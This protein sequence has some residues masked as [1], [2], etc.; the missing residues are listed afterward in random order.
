MPI[1]DVMTRDRHFITRKQEQLAKRKKDG[2]PFDRM[3]SEL[4][5]M[6]EK[7]AALYQARLGSLPKI[8]YDES[9]PVA[10][11]SEE[12]VK[13]IQDNQVVIIA[14][15][16]GSGKTTQLPK[17]CL[18]AG[19]G[20]AG[21]IGHTQPRRIAARS[22]AER[23]SDEMQVKLGEQ[24]GFQVRFN[25][26][27]NEETLIK[28]MT[29]G[30]L[31]AEIQQ[32]K[33]LYK[34]DTII[35]DEAHERSLNIDFL[36]GYL[37]RVLALRPDLKVIVTSATIDVE[38]FSAHFN[39]APVIEVS[40]RT[41]PVEIRYQPL[42][43]KS[44]SEALDEDQSMEQGILDAVEQLIQEERQSGYRGAGD[45]LVFLAGER[46]I[47]ETAEILRR[48][49]LRNTE[50]LPLYARLSTSEQQRIFKSHSG[51]RIVLSTNV[52]ETSL[53]VPGIRYVIDPGLAR[54]SRY[55]VRSKVQQ[56]P[57]EKI[58]QASANQRAGRCGRVAE[59]VCIRLYDE[60]DFAARS[61]FTDPE[62]FRT[63][64]AS[65]ILQMANLR[66]GAV[67]KFP[68]VEM[69]ERRM[70]ND[71][72][73]ALT[74]LGALKG[75]QLTPIGRQLAKLPI[76]PKFG[77]ILIAA[78]Q[79]SVLKEVAV[80]VSA[81]SVPDPRERPQDKK[82]QSDQA[83]AQDKDE[84]SDFVVL[85]NLWERFEEQRQTLSQNQL[86]QYCRKQFLNFMR[87]R[88][89]RDIHRQI[90]IACKQLGFKEVDHENRNYEAIHRSLLAG[91]FTHVA[92]KMDDSK[93]MLGC[94]S[95]KVSIFPGS[96][97]F[98]K[99]PQW[100][101]AAELV[102]TSKLYARVT[103]RIDPEWIEEF[104]KPFVKRQYFDPHFERNQGR[105]MAQEQVSL[106]G[107]IIVAKRRVDYGQI[108]PE[109]AREILIRAGLVEGQ[110]RTKQAFYRHNKA[111]VEA[112][113][114]QEA[115]LRTR[116]ILVD[117]EAVFA[118]YDQR[119]PKEVRNQKGLEYFVKQSPD[120]LL[121]T[122][123]DLINQEVSVDDMAFPDTYG[124][125]G[126]ALP[127][128]YRFEPG[129]VTDGATLKVPVGL[130]RQLSLDELGWAVPGFIKER[131]EALLRALPKALRR[132][133]V[134]I[135]QFVER[136]Y[137]NLSKDKGDLLEQL[138]LQIKRETLI[139]I[140]LN[141]WAPE[142][143][144]THLTLT[145][146]VVDERGKVL[147]FG[148]DLAE[149]QAR[150]S[151]LVEESF[152][153]FGT[154]QH[155]QEDLTQWPEQ[156]IP[157]RQE[158]KQAGIK[159]TAFP[160]LV[161]QGEAVSLK[162]FDDHSTAQEAHRKGVIALL[163]IALQKDVRYLQ[164]NLPHLRESMLIFAPLG[165]KEVLLNDLLNAILDKVFLDG[166]AL[167]RTQLE[168]EQC[169]SAHKPQ[170][171]SVA[172]EMA[173]QLYRVLS[174]YQGVAKKMKGSIPL[175]WTRVYGD[176]KLQLENLIYPGFIGSTPL[177]WLGQLPRY[178]KG[179]E[180]RL[181]RFQ[182]HLNKENSYVT[183]LEG[184]WQS[185][186]KQKKA[187]DEKS[188]YDPELIKYRWMLEEYR[189]S[190]F[191]QSVGT[192]EPISDKRLGKQWQAVKKLV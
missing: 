117:D 45:I 100:V 169:I 87:M 165:Q 73:R 49:E 66:L 138:S 121:M 177:F 64:L 22:V 59:G 97:L 92:N 82:T 35:I 130:L 32:D 134:P 129:K 128:D 55:S 19:R 125:N 28:L 142:R 116:D 122:R 20:I 26:E 16:T 160:A 153:K 192:L 157:E 75:E 84:D 172:N 6:M 18:E 15:E 76:D 56:L 86:R 136:I 148:K 104:A 131:C 54:M 181:E 14:G 62:I 162:M 23:I 174:S 145:L 3:A 27:S 101:M 65:V 90:L 113:E 10:A 152:A 110:M 94:R 52:A 102:E 156:D 118:F 103:A 37:K 79:H 50:V 99:P 21:L 89:W 71:G 1:T 120:A 188:L 127:I 44:D 72:Y 163:K 25:D 30:I 85:L 48:A 8:T 46:E 170:L 69:P 182:N 190:L 115:K 176:I 135:P 187:H 41:Y 168:F 33:L 11:R 180:V 189:I 61:E 17:M 42:L 105:V 31:L 139:D 38:R 39:N 143:L 96:M 137:P 167:P 158:I 9:L 4:D 83:H 107:L 57:I 144:E 155:E 123:E 5:A 43:S 185:Y 175:P 80:I 179:I 132:R 159:V 81:L 178:F 119:I 7:S 29:D 36:L 63:N 70:I 186:L 53:T 111:L 112:L 146:E 184:L 140:P 114:T 13:A 151:D 154:K 95:R 78:E 166:R 60:A 2:L 141:E 149:L 34:Y 51:R 161:A 93:E 74:E 88:E 147:G 47:R 108:E 133:F 40:G 91:L 98:K 173:N 12:I 106:Y 109:E 68:F 183:Q 24:V 150:F 67:E 124:L 77:R 58:S 191:A 171:V 126:V 164:K